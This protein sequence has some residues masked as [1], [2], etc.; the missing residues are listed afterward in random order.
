MNPRR[1]PL[2]VAAIAMLA[3]TACEKPA[4]QITVASSGRVYNVDAFNYCFDGKCRDRGGVERKVRVRG[5]TTVSFDVPRRVADKGYVIQIGEQS[6][7]QA[8]RKE[9]HYALSFPAAREQTLPVTI[10]ETGN[11]NTPT[12]VWKLQF[13]VKD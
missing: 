10:V 6:L 2:A 12:G 9:S 3:L 13:D 4:P 8:P 1:L 5:N 7:F 11:G